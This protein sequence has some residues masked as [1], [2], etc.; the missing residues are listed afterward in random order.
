MLINILKL[1]AVKLTLMSFH[2]QIKMKAVH[3][4]IGNATVLSYLLN[5]GYWEQ[6]TFGLGQGYMGLYREEWDHDYAEY[7]GRLPV[8][9]SQGQFRL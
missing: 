5:M 8:K 1:K 4:Q 9:E 6:E 2:K 3:F 7:G